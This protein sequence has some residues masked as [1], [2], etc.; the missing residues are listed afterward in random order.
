MCP[1]SYEEFRLSSYDIKYLVWSSTGY[2]VRYRLMVV[3]LS[4]LWTVS[5]D[6]NIH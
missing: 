4:D 1:T 2:D 6:S 5:E 3:D